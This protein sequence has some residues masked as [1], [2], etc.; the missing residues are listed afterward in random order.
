M[1]Y[2]LNRLFVH[3]ITADPIIGVRRIGDYATIFEDFNDPSDESP[4]RVLGID[5]DN[6]DKGFASKK[7]F[8]KSQLQKGE[9][10]QAA[11]FYY[12]HYD[13]VKITNKGLINA[14]PFAIPFAMPLT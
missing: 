14:N 5:F 8:L 10:I 4:L 11:A 3:N 12:E 9:A 7:F 1:V 6:H 13:I 2:F